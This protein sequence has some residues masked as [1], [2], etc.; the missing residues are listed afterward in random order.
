MIHIVS[1]FEV[2][3]AA[4]IIRDSIQVEQRSSTGGPGPQGGPKSYCRLLLGYQHFVKNFK[5]L[6][7]IQMS[8][9]ESHILSANINQPFCEEKTH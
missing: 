3:D 4:L 2:L 6:S 5:V 8:Q 1:K 9:H 7:K